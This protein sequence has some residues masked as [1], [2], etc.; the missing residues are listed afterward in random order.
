MKKI[1]GILTVAALLLGLT[2]SLALAKKKADSGHGWLGVVTQ[3][4]DYEMADAFDLGVKYGAIIN[5]VVDDSPADEAGIKEG[6][7]IVRLN[8]NRITDSEDLVESLSETESGEKV[9]LTVIRD[10]DKV[11]LTATLD[12]S[13]DQDVFIHLDG[14]GHLDH[15]KGLDNLKHLGR[16]DFDHNF[17]FNFGDSKHSY[18]GVTLIDL[19][20]QLGG[21][22]GVDDGKGVLVESV[23]DDSPAKNAGVLAG[24]VIIGIDE[25][26]V[27]GSRDLRSY[28]LDRKEGDQVTLSILRDR[29]QQKVTVEVGIDESGSGGLFG[30]WNSPDI[31]IIRVPQLRGLL[32]GNFQAPV[33]EFDEEE[34]HR[35]MEELRRELK[36]MERELKKELREIEERLE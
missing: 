17:S 34:L 4:V 28:V 18:I 12:D 25:E 6:D 33:I 16:L 36:E 21:Y 20:N 10:G 22:F 27:E 32:R 7:V 26:E 2:Y 31:D 13:Q 30:H 5:K 8:G 29:K 11:Q 15:L 1:I 3:S 35:D 9:N 19:S 23:L 14:L 24:D